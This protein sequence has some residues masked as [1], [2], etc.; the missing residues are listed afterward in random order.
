MLFGR[1]EATGRV[2]RATVDASDVLGYFVERQEDEVI[3]GPKT[4]R[5]VAPNCPHALGR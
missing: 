3:V 4:L 2:W 1:R 5:N